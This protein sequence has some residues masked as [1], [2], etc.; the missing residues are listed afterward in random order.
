MTGVAQSVAGLTVGL[1]FALLGPVRLGGMA[2]LCAAQAFLVAVGALAQGEFW[3]AAVEVVEAGVIGWFGGMLPLPLEAWA[4][5]RTRGGG[6]RRG[7]TNPFTHH[8]S[9]RRPKLPPAGRLDYLRLAAGTALAILAAAIPETGLPLAVVLLG[10]LLLASHVLPWQQTLGIAAMQNGLVLAALATGLANGRLAL[11][12]VPWLPAMA[13][14]ALWLGDDR[15]RIGCLLAPRLAAWIDT[16]LC[17]LALLLAC[18]LPWQIGAHGTYWRLDAPAVH[19]I[20]LLAA[21]ATA[22]SWARR[23]STPRGSNRRRARAIGGAP[24]VASVR[25]SPGT[26][27]VA[28]GR[29]GDPAWR[30]RLAT[31]VTTIWRDRGAHGPEDASVPDSHDPS[32]IERSHDAAAAPGKRDSTTLLGSHN[33][34]PRDS[35]A[36]TVWRNVTATIQDGRAATVR[37]ATTVWGGCCITTVWGSRLAILTGCVVAILVTAPLLSWLGIALAT[38]G[39]MADALPARVDAWRRLGLGCTGLGLALFGVVALHAAAPPLPVTGCAMLGYGTLAIL[40]P[41]LTVAAVAL[42]LHMRGPA[43]EGLLLVLGLAALLIAAV[44]LAFLPAAVPGPAVRGRSPRGPSPRGPSPPGSSPPGSYQFVPSPLGWSPIELFARGPSTRGPQPGMWPLVALA[45]AGVAVFAF[46]LG[47]DAG[48]LAGLL[49]LSLLTLTECALLLARRDGV[50]R[51][52]A[53]AGLAGVP[54]F[55]LF[56]SLALVLSATAASLPWL[57]VPLGAGLASVAWALLLHLPAERRLLPSAAWVPLALLLIVG[58]AMPDPLLAWFRLA[59][60]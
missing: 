32:R 26:A 33:A 29:S 60:R 49:Q 6:T 7:R 15:G 13:V 30:S 55:G 35:R 41:E 28:G 3:V 48:N 12:V 58:F 46:G 43:T 56:P 57:L 34:A 59:A 31:L 19:V 10:L 38:A 1:G 47:T 14:A 22:A 52:F 27:A 9:V 5:T 36:R 44:G 51:I 21:L 20:V 40:A 23:N 37:H 2:L 54:P 50:D 24:G 25:G 11:V 17:S 53:I 4:A 8:W 16:A 42:I 18:A 39:A 45:H